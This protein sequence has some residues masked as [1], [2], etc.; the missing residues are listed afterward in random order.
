MLLALLQLEGRVRSNDAIVFLPSHHVVNDEEVMTRRSA[1]MVEWI[2]S[3]PRLVFLVGAKPE[4]PPANWP[5][6]FLGT[7]RCKCR[8][9]CTNLSNTGRAAS[10]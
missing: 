2:A 8:V 9:V 4:Q 3:A 10:T 7:M 1:I 6:W 5:T